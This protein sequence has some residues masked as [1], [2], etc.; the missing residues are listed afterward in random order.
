M[1]LSESPQTSLFDRLGGEEALRPL[2]QHFYS[3]VRQHNVI[4]PIFLRQI[5]DWSQHLE[6]ILRFWTTVTGGPP[7]Y[8]GP[9][10]IAHL[11]LHLGAEHFEF[12]LDLWRRHCRLRFPASEA[13]A[14]IH[15]AETMADRLQGG[16]AL[17]IQ[18]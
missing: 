5:D 16:A 18:T 8:S 2:L 1:T 14:L 10:L 9:M 13:E 12:W 15:I 4:G 3:D 11:K 6:K 7:C 17:N